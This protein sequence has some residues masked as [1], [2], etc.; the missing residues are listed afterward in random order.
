MELPSQATHGRCEDREEAGG[1]RR[2]SC[3]RRRRQGNTRAT[4]HSAAAAHGRPT[5]STILT[6]AQLRFERERLLKEKRSRSRPLACMCVCAR[7][8]CSLNSGTA[9]M[10]RTFERE[11]S[12]GREQG[13]G[14][15][16]RP[17]AA[18]G[19]SGRQHLSATACL[20]PEAPAGNSRLAQYSVHRP[21]SSF[22]RYSLA[23]VFLLATHLG[24]PSCLTARG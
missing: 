24:E 13:E 12:K 15:C 9:N 19:D 8:V 11:K 21:C 7:V 17:H 6:A 22:Y 14:A 4:Q 2:E 18:V 1:S 10:D 16:R 5:T 20:L 3:R 23:A